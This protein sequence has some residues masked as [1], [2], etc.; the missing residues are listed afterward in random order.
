MRIDLWIDQS[1]NVLVALRVSADTATQAQAFLLELHV[2]EM[3]PPGLT[4]DAPP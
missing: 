2:T 3:D 1:R 4:I